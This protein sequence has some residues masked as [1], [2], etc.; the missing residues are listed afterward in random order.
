MPQLDRVL[1][2]D[3]KTSDP[4]DVVVDTVTHLD[5]LGVFEELLQTWRESVPTAT[6][7]LDNTWNTGR[8]Q[9]NMPAHCI[10]AI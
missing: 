10:C 6:I 7:V 8:G 2:G 5:D 4:T 1:D 3:T 9:E